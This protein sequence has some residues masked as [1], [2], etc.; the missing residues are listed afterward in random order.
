MGDIKPKPKPPAPDPGDD[1]FQ[2]S[3]MGEAAG[4]SVVMPDIAGWNA[5]TPEPTPPPKGYFPPVDLISAWQRASAPPPPPQSAG[6]GATGAHPGAQADDQPEG[7]FHFPTVSNR[8]LVV[9][10]VVGVVVVIGL[11][12]SYYLFLRPEPSPVAVTTPRPSS[13]P[14]ARP[15]YKPSP[16]PSFKP[17]PNP[18]VPP[19]PTPAGQR[20][21][22]VVPGDTLITIGERFGVDWH[23]IA[24]ANGQ[25]TD[26]NYITPGQ[27]LKIP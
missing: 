22:T 23:A 15:T 13:K 24:A 18:V 7:G 20:T 17:Q 10:T 25:I 14:S 27:V 6:A 3:A 26:P 11:G 19:Q 5:E 1:H 12:G 8:L 21:Y 16:R 4:S 9:L 2:D